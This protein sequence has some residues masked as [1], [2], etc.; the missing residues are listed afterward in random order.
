[1]D[2]FQC[3]KCGH[4]CRN[5]KRL[6]RLEDIGADKRPLYILEEDISLSLY[7]WEV[8]DFQLAGEKLGKRISVIPVLICIDQ[9]SNTPLSLIWNILDSDCP[10]LSE[11]NLCLIYEQRPIIC[12]IF[13]VRVSGI[14]LRTSRLKFS[15]VFQDCKYLAQLEIPSVLRYGEFIAML[16]NC[17]GEIHAYS[18]HNERVQMILI[19]FLRDLESNGIIRLARN[20]PLKFVK[21]LVARRGA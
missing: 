8:E 6:R 11:S 7:E 3:R 5:L 17:F 1:M 9:L 12:R 18:F 2:K 10:F 19:D 20:R 21:N 14:F 16:H 15:D 13:P 4:C